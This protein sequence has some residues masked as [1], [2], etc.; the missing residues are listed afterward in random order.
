MYRGRQ[1]QREISA[2]VWQEHDREEHRSTW[3]IDLDSSAVL[4]RYDRHDIDEA[5]RFSD[6]A[7]R[8]FIIG[9]LVV[10]TAAIAMLLF[11]GVRFE[12]LVVVVAAIEL[13]RRVFPK[14]DAAVRTLTAQCLANLKAVSKT[15][16]H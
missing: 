12:L 3:R 2:S 8:P 9:C 6:R 16:R 1:L 11:Q 5:I 10:I 14:E 7:F 13:T 15:P 4:E